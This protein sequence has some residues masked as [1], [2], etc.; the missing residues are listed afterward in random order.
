MAY[1]N[2]VQTQPEAKLDVKQELAGQSLIIERVQRPQGVLLTF[3]GC[4]HS[5]LDWWHPQPACKACIGGIDQLALKHSQRSN[6][7]LAEFRGAC[8]LDVTMLVN[9]RNTV[10]A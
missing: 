9:L 8:G 7:R 1:N 3:H 2:Q 6:W 5:A 4:G 10:Q